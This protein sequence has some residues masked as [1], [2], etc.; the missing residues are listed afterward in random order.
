MNFLNLF[1]RLRKKSKNF[2]KEGIFIYK[3]AKN[4][5]RS[6]KRS[7]KGVNKRNLINGLPGKLIILIFLSR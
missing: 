4:I 6:A 3:V 2:E 1:Y 7:T 5:H